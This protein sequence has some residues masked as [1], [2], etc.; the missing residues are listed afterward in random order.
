MYQ[1]T[2]QSGHYTQRKEDTDRNILLKIREFLHTS[3]RLKS[4]LVTQM[5]KNLLAMQKTWVGKIP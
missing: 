3:L 5:V 2:I 4:S 1:I